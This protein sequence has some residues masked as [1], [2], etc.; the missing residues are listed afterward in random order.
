MKLPDHAFL[1]T[2]VH[3]S[4][5][6]AGGQLTDGSLP[7]PSAFFDTDVGVCKRPPH[8][9]HVAFVGAWGSHE[10]RVLPFSIFVARAQ[11][12]CAVAIS[13]SSC[14]RVMCEEKAGNEVAYQNSPMAAAGACL[15][16][17]Q[18]SYRRDRG[19]QAYM[20]LRAGPRDVHFQPRAAARRA[21]PGQIQSLAPPIRRI[22]AWCWF[23]LVQ[24]I[25]L[26]SIDVN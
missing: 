1:E 17:C 14:Q 12:A 11:H 15:S 10:I 13:L 7:S 2:H 8:V 9:G 24:A 18:S 16:P 5:L 23:K 25:Q 6:F 19:S 20:A 4:K 22:D 3:A 26:M 21:P